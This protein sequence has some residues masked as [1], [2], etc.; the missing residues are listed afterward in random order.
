MPPVVETT[1]HPRVLAAL[2]DSGVSYVMRR[3]GDCAV[4]IKR[5]ED[6]AQCLGRSVDAITKS[7]FLEL[8]NGETPGGY[9]I[10]VCSIPRRVDFTV[11]ARQWNVPVVRLATRAELAA[12]LGYPPTGVS[13]L[14]GQGF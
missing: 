12:A 4:P 1:L 6:F 13:P 3:H 7:L 5:P 11:L 10:A 14:G 9:A 2:A 8:R